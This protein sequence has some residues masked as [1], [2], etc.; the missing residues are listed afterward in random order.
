M[1]L[2]YMSCNKETIT[3]SPQEVASILVLSIYFCLSFLKHF[4]C[5]YHPL[6]QTYMLLYFSKTL[7]SQSTHYRPN[8]FTI[9]LRVKN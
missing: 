9:Y 8:V 4:N 5:E 1:Y 2:H 7:K 6:L 3:D